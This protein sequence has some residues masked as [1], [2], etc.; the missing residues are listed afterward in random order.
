M[1]R[2]TEAKPSELE[3][4][5]IVQF[6]DYDLV[7]LNEPPVV[8]GVVTDWYVDLYLSSRDDAQHLLTILHLLDGNREGFHSVP[9]DQIIHVLGEM[10]LSAIRNHQNDRIKKSRH[11]PDLQPTTFGARLKP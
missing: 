7:R 6:V 1:I 11:V 4:G 2:L 9:P 5:H 8:Y 3:V 10:T